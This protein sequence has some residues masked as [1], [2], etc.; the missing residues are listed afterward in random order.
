MENYRKKEAKGETDMKII[1]TLDD[2]NHTM[3]NH[4]RQSRDV[5]VRAKIAELTE[6]SMLWMNDYSGR[7]FRD[8]K[9]EFC[10]AEDFLDRAKE[11]DYCFVEDT[12]IAGAA[13]EIEEFIIFRWNRKYP[14]DAGPDLLPW[15]S[16]FSCVGSEEF[17]GNSHEKITMEI[18]RREQ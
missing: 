10:T 7:Q 1:L 18:W 2:N 13:A 14:G 17:P 8:M 3:F 6:G 4:R 9:M 5:A 11:G 12:G 16:G 15:E